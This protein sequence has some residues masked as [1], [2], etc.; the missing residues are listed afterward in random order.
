M[1]FRRHVTP[2]GGG[3]GR[4]RVHRARGTWR[5]STSGR[6]ESGEQSRHDGAAARAAHNVVIMLHEE[7]R[8]RSASFRQKDVKPRQLPRASRRRSVTSRIRP[9]PRLARDAFGS[10]TRQTRPGRTRGTRSRTCRALQKET[11]VGLQERLLVLHH[12][13]EHRRVRPVMGA[14]PTEGAVGDR[15]L[16]PLRVASPRRRSVTKDLDAYDLYTSTGRISK[17]RRR[18]SSNWSTS[19]RRSRCWAPLD[20]QEDQRLKGAPPTETALDPASPRSPR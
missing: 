7:D 19:R 12:L 20:G 5:V 3:E 14:N 2:G 15:S 17:L 10:S 11:L 9:R 4:R 1:G 13:R 8:A 18:S 6:R 16:D